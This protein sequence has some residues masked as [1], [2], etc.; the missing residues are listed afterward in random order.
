MAAGLLLAFKKCLSFDV[1]HLLGDPGYLQ[2]TKILMIVLY[3]PITVQA[4]KV[5]EYSPN[6]VITT[7]LIG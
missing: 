2:N 6:W 3:D 1:G 4:C 5:P 7:V